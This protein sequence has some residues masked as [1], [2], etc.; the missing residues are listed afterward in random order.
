[1]WGTRKTNT[2]ITQPDIFQQLDEYENIVIELM[3]SQSQNY[4][5]VAGRNL[6]GFIHYTPFSCSFS[7]LQL[8][9]MKK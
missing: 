1:M 7:G 6:I 4:R 3:E 5:F 9:K 2:I 8:A